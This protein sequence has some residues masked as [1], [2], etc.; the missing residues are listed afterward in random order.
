MLAWPELRALKLVNF[1]RACIDSF[2]MDTRYVLNIYITESVVNCHE[3]LTWK[4][5]RKTDLIFP[6]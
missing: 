3:N 6:F 1:F 4:D 2:I 5:R